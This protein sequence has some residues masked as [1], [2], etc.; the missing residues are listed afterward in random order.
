MVN[1]LVYCIDI[2][3]D[4]LLKTPNCFLKSDMSKHVNSIKKKWPKEENKKRKEEKKTK[5]RREKGSE[6]QVGEGK[7]LW[8]EAITVPEHPK[9]L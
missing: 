3:S 5:G 7:E 9:T 1:G 4:C 2:I 8:E 6:G